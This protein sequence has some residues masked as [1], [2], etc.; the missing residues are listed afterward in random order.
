M[1]TLLPTQMFP[2][3][4]ASA[5]FVADTEIVSDFVQKYFVSATNVSQENIMTNNVS[6][7]M[8]PRLQVPYYG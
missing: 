7:T 4:S 5:T 1:N 8:C 6:A 3:L 2:R